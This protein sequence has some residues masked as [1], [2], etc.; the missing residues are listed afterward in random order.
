MFLFLADGYVKF[1]DSHRQIPV[2]PV[3]VAMLYYI[4][5][6]AA[7]IWWPAT[8]RKHQPAFAIHLAQLGSVLASARLLQRK[9][10]YTNLAVV[11][12]EYALGGLVKHR[13]RLDSFT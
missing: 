2:A 1:A 4:N 3:F 9:N 10:K 11:L 6:S 13:Y 8:S 12:L 5:A 7:F